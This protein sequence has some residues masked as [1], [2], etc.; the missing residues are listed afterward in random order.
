MADW[1]DDEDLKNLQALFSCYLDHHVLK[2]TRQRRRFS[3]TDEK[4]VHKDRIPARMKPDVKYLQSL[5][6]HLLGRKPFRPT[7][8]NTELQS[9]SSGIIEEVSV[10]VDSAKTIGESIIASMIGKSVSQHKFS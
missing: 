1:P 9:I 7:Y 3:N 4:D 8:N 10:N 6:D 2:Y 5:L